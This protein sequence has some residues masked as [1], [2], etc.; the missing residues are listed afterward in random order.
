[1]GEPDFY[2]VE[3]AADRLR[4]GRTSA[5]LAAKQYRASGGAEGLPVIAIRG[6]LRVP[7]RKLEEWA[8]GALS[9]PDELAGGDVVPTPPVLEVI[10]DPDATP[11]PKPTSTRVRATRPTPQLDLFDPPSAS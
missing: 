1:V 11:T 2:T 9:D 5:Y 3:E 6:S 8:G 7:R 10:S 4:I